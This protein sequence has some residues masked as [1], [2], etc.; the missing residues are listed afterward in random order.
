MSV[1]VDG[2]QSNELSSTTHFANDAN[3]VT[4][5]L[6]APRTLDKILYDTS[7]TEDDQ[8]IRKFLAKPSVL[9]SGLFQT[10]DT[11]STFPNQD[12]PQDL[13]LLNTIY[14]DKL[15]GFMGF[16]ATM[17]FRIQVNG[18]RFQ[19]GR[20]MMTWVP[21]AGQSISSTNAALRIAS[22]TNTLVQRT[23][24]PRVELDISCDTEATL[25]V[26]FNSVDNFYPLR[27]VGNSFR[28]LGALRIFPYSPLVAPSGSSNCSFTVWAWFTDVEL[29][30]ATV[31]Q[32]SISS[33]EAKMNGVGPISSPLLAVSRSFAALKAIPMISDYASNLSWVTE[34]MSK[35]A[36]IFGWAKPLNA[37][38]TSFVQRK[39]MPGYCHVEGVDNSIMLAMT[40]K[41]EVSVLPGFSCTNTDEMDFSFFNS[42]SAYKTQFTWSSTAARG[43]QL[44]NFDVGPKSGLSTR[45][46][47]NGQTIVDMIPF[48]FTSQY[49]K[50]WRGSLTYTFKIVKTEF[51]SGRLA[52]VFVPFEDSLSRPTRSYDNSDYVHREIVDVRESSVVTITVPFVSLTPF[53]QLDSQGTIGSFHV[54]V[55][56]T[57]VAPSTVSSSVTILVEAAGGPDLVYAVPRSVQIAPLYNATP[58]MNLSG[59][60]PSSE[61]PCK[62]VNRVIGSADLTMDNGETSAACVGELITSYRSLIKSPHLLNW[63]VAPS[64]AAYLQISPYLYSFKNNSVLSGSP[65]TTTDL[66]GMLMSIYA[67]S[68]GGMRFKMFLDA[69]QCKNYSPITSMYIKEA[70]DFPTDALLN[71]TNGNPLGNPVATDYLNFRISGPV[72]LHH[73]YQNQAL[74]FSVPQYDLRHSRANMANSV[75]KLF[76]AAVSAGNLTSRMIVTVSIPYQATINKPYVARVAAEDTNFG[77]FVSIPPCNLVGGLPFI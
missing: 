16:R 48:Q 67:V 26:P 52:F 5:T 73:G 45:T 34:R 2:T 62:I 36:S 21:T 49:F 17:N 37:S 46:D 10:T 63:N 68:R 30:A 66:I 28:S 39:V 3:V 58:Q 75:S 44:L 77:T 25:I 15:D 64:A 33:R 59:S 55:V 65:S 18:N 47:L 41:N 40:D 38:N 60:T 32:M 35:A 53:R 6:Q 19:Q 51:H 57:L 13:L 72:M 76:P 42:V 31:P 43:D 29:V 14:L 23:Q 54:Y 56:D 27:S 61:D 70:G 20:Y 1:S 8:S 22:H 24:L 74:E 12:L 11:V 71:S 4:A 50:Y 7:T 9:L 69:E